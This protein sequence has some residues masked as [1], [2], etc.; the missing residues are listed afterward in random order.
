MEGDAWDVAL[1]TQFPASNEFR[2]ING[3]HL[4]RDGG[5]TLIGSLIAH[6]LIDDG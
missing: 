5:V 3:I 6:A 4:V 1:A 2:F